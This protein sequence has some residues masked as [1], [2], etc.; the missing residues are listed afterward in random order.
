MQAFLF[1]LTGFCTV[2]KIFLKE[3]SICSENVILAYAA[4]LIVI[5]SQIFQDFY[6]RIE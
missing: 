2:H 5:D 1:F 3:M 6:P 4:L